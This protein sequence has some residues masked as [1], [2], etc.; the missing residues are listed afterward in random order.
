MFCHLPPPDNDLSGLLDS[1]NTFYAQSRQT[2]EGFRTA[3]PLD[4]RYRYVCGDSNQNPQSVQPDS[5]DPNIDQSNSDQP[6]TDQTSQP[7]TPPVDS[8]LQIIPTPDLTQ[9]IIDQ[10]NVAQPT[11]LDQEPTPVPP[12]MD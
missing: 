10:S 4:C 12:M 3:A 1:G 5:E 9:P 7:P 6:T 11:Q 2:G 8:G